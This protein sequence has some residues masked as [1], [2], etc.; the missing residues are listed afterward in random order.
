MAFRTWIASTASATDRIY[1]LPPGWC[2]L[3]NPRYGEPV[4]A[5]Q[6]RAHEVEP[7]RTWINPTKSAPDHRNFVGPPR[8]RERR[9]LTQVYNRCLARAASARLTP[10]LTNAALQPYDEAPGTGFPGLHSDKK[11]ADYYF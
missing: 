2:L 3:F 9:C 4:L 1:A 7:F 8:G 5:R 10:D 11:W 6:A